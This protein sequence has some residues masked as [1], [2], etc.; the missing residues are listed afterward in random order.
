MLFMFRRTKHVWWRNFCGLN[1][2]MSEV[3]Y[4][5]P[6]FKQPTLCVYDQ[7]RLFTCVLVS[8]VCRRM[9]R[10]L[11]TSK[12]L[13]KKDDEACTYVERG[14]TIH[15]SFLQWIFN[16][17]MA[18]LRKRARTFL[19]VDWLIIPNIY[20]V[21]HV[22]S[23]QKR[24]KTRVSRAFFDSLTSGGGHSTVILVRRYR[25]RSIPS[26]VVKYPIIHYLLLR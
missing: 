22:G 15:K 19:L 20:C 6:S 16:I 14:V 3:I 8:I 4:R 1:H 26:I 18:R 11:L 2:L 5:R 24:T 10:K 23:A 17:R 12:W 7:I 21:E 25:Y 9:V 13:A